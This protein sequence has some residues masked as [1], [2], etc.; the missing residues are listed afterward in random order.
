M[1]AGEEKRRQAVLAR[2]SRVRSRLN[3]E[4]YSRAAVAPVWVAATLFV[5]GWG[6]STWADTVLLHLR[7]P[8]ETGYRIPRGGLY[9]WVSCPNYLGKILEWSGWALATWSWAGLAFAVY[10]FANLAPRA[11][12]NH[13]WYRATFPDYPRDRKALIPLVW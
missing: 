13:R 9:R 7:K 3:L 10:T 2:I 8:G 12:L 4:I 5:L 1:A 11:M 6:M